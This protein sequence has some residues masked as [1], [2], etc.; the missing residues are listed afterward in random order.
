MRARE[1]C[2]CVSARVFESLLL[3]GLQSA[4]GGPGGRGPAPLDSR[5]LVPGRSGLQGFMH[6][7][8]GGDWRG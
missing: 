4:G 3:P 1:N 5:M 6:G 8:E 7:L 2:A